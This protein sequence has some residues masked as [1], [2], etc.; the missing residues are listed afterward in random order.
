MIRLYKSYK[1]V[2]SINTYKETRKYDVEDISKPV[3]ITM[4]LFFGVIFN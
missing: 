4:T 2:C 3:T 1:E